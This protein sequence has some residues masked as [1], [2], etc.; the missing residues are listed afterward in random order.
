M[1]DQSPAVTAAHPPEAMLRAANPILR[2]LLRTPLA[3][4]ARKQFMVVTISGR[5]TG[6][7]YEIPVSAHRIDNDL[8]AITNAGWRHNFRDGATAEVLY[9][10]QKKTMRGELI[11]DRAAAAELF[12]RCAESYGVTRAQRMMGLKFRDQRIPTSEDF[13][14]AIGREHLVAIRLTPVQ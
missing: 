10:G 14:E 3:G 2:F 5:K 13:A 8:Y 12:H 7:R 11:Q 4:P 1:T 9:D 6:R